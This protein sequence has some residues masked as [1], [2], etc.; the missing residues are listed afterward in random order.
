MA[1]ALMASKRKI[2]R[3]QCGD[4]HRHTDRITAI[5]AAD[6]LRHR[7]ESTL[8]VYHCKWCNG[9]HVGHLPGNLRRF[10]RHETR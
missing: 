8:N 1:G 2:R 4:K 7:G 10:T 9:W 5:R 3:K 6:S